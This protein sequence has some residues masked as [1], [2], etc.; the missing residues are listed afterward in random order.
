MSFG[1]VMRKFLGKSEER[2][3]FSELQ[4]EDRLQHRVQER[5]KNSN[6]RELER[7]QEENRQKM[8]K[9]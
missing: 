8:I 6:E 3:K 4:Q 7:F 9:E 1:E 2:E 5:K